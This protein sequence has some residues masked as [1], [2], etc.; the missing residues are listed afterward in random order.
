MM[1]GMTKA[2]IAI[3]IDDEKLRAVR[4]R[5]AAGEAPSVSAYVEHAVARTL[6][7]A[8]DWDEMVERDLEAT[9]GPLTADERAWVDDVLA[10]RAGPPP[11]D[12]L[13]RQ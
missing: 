8:D 7:D 5:V 6:D 3:S 9:G 4:A 11:T 1:N 12:R 10:G 2:K 13:S